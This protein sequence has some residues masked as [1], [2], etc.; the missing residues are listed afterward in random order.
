MDENENGYLDKEDD[1]VIY[2]GICY[3]IT[4]HGDHNAILTF[5]GW[6]FN[7]AMEDDT[8]EQARAED[9]RENMAIEWSGHIGLIT[10]KEEGLYHG[11]L[12]GIFIGELPDPEHP[13]P[14]KDFERTLYE[15]GRIAWRCKGVITR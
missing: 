4:V 15:D 1:V 11:I 2:S 5:P 12:D 13:C 8:I 9:L 7:V 6:T 10:K 3:Y 14:F